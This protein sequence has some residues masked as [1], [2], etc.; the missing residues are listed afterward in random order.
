M[1]LY[2]YNLRLSQ[3]FY[4]LLHISEVVLRNTINRQLQLFYQEDNWILSKERMTHNQAEEVT[5]ACS[6]LTNHQSEITA[7]KIISELNFSFWTSFFSIQ[8]YKFHR[9]QP[10]KIFGKLPE[11]LGRKEIYVLLNRIRKFRNRIYHNEPICF[12]NNTIDFMAVQLVYEDITFLLNHLCPELN[13]FI[14]E[15]DSVKQEIASARR[16]F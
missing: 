11:N 10:I 12:K 1:D 5:R 7:G 16:T 15:N 9:G 14:S 8:N 4:P 13:S 6:F 2:R 3:S